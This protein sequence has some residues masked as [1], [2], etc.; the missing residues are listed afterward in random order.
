M[1]FK[2]FIIGAG[3]FFGA[4]MRYLVSGWIQSLSQS[5]R[6]P[7]GTL[8]VNLIGCFLMGLFFQAADT[9]HFFS[10]HTRSLIFVGF[11]GAFTTFSTF[12]NETAILIQDGR[13]ALAFWNM[14]LHLAF[15]LFAVFIGRYS[16]M[17]IWR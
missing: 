8:A 1:L 15:G 6:F 13:E 14:F 17:L 3:G 9:R 2:L 5:Y 7:W 12:G 16:A 4:I 11:L 10:E